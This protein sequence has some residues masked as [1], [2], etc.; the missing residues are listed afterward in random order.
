VDAGKYH[1]L[2]CTDQEEFGGFGRVDMQ[3]TYRSMMERSFGLKHNL[4][5]YLPSRSA[6]VLQRQEIPRVR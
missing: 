1:P 6:I 2:L 3:M 4:K 5:L